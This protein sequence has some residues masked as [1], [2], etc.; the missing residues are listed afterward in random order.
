MCCMVALS[1]QKA[2]LIEMRLERWQFAAALYPATTATP[3][4]E[5][6]DASVASPEASME[7]WDPPLDDRVRCALLQSHVQCRRFVSNVPRT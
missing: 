7:T 2:S 1:T 4:T 5:G 6:F 3:T